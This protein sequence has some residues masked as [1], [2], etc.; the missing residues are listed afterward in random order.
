MDA[1]VGGKLGIDF[2]GLKNHIGVFQIPNAVLIDA[3]TKLKQAKLSKNA[4]VLTPDRITFE[5]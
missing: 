4:H 5:S 1:S 3:D 2:Q